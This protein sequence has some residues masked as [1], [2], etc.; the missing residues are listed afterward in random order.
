MKWRSEYAHPLL[1]SSDRQD[2]AS[3]N[4][5]RVGKSEATIKGKR[6][7]QTD[8]VLKEFIFADGAH[9]IADFDNFDYDRNNANNKSSSQKGSSSRAKNSGRYSAQLSN[10]QPNIQND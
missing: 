4:A 5:E 6:L 8:K 9:Q 7:S 1:I 10:E 3:T 2:V